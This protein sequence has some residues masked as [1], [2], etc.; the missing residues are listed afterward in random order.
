MG[1]LLAS[2]TSSDRLR[3]AR[4]YESLWLQSVAAAKFD[5]ADV[6]LGVDQ[7]AE[8]ASTIQPACNI[9]DRFLEQNEG[10]VDRRVSPYA[11][12]LMGRA[13]L[14]LR[15]GEP[16][17]ALMLATQALQGVRLSPSSIDRHM[18][19]IRVLAVGST[20]LQSLG[21]GGQSQA[22]ARQGLQL[23]PRSIELRPA[24]KAVVAELHLRAGN[25]A[26]AQQLIS[27]LSAMGY[28]HPLYRAGTAAVSGA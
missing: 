3:Y 2:G 6:Q 20:A 12:C 17:E 22:W 28:R 4:S 7:I 21:R 27:S 10:S 14:A 11:K 16:D 9:V 19:E 1:E 18:L 23:I 13:R 24:E 5:L 26:A 8:A 15:E 25:R